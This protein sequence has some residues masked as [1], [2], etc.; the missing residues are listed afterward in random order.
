MCP[1]V[2][3]SWGVKEEEMEDKEWVKQDSS[4]SHTLVKTTEPR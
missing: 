1:S 3:W 4:I 2:C